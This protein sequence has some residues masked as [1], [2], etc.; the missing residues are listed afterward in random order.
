MRRILFI[1]AIALVSLFSFL[2]CDVENNNNDISIVLNNDSI[3]LLIGET[4]TLK[5]TVRNGDVIVDCKVMWSTD[6]ES[7]AKVDTNGVVTALNMGI[8]MILAECQGAS[9][10]CEVVVRQLPKK[11]VC[12]YVDLGLSVKWATCN[13]GAEKPEDYGDYYAWGETEPKSV[14]N[15]LTYKFRTS[16]DSF[17]N[18]KFNKYNTESKHGAVDNKIVLDPEDDVAHVKWGGNWRMPTREEFVELRNNCTWTFT[19][20]NGVKGC[21]FTSNISG[22]EDRSIFLP[23]GGSRDEKYIINVGSWSHYRSSSLSQNDDPCSAW[24]MY[25]SLLDDFMYVDYNGRV[26][27]YSVRPVCP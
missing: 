9:V 26:A 24:G 2:G 22:Y 15:W 6:N 13:V 10:A 25:F 20:K 17:E 18:V 5:A 21:L 16:G 7:V 11:L 1:C 19:T 12:E 27:G 3:S 14:Y 4:E 8:A 23:A